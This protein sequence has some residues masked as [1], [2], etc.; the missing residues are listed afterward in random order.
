MPRT[1]ISGL[2]ESSILSFLGTSMLTFIVSTLIH[3]PT[4]S[5]EVFFL[6]PPI[7]YS[8]FQQH[9]FNFLPSLPPAIVV[10]FIGSHSAINLDT[11]FKTF[12]LFSVAHAFCMCVDASVPR[13]L[14]VN[15]AWL[16]GVGSLLLVCWSSGLNCSHWI[17]QQVPESALPSS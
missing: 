17:W 7:L 13:L 11:D 5:L 8:L 9:L 6:F 4:N 14:C 15:Q 1:V 12:C 3:F 16:A 10:C 2:Y